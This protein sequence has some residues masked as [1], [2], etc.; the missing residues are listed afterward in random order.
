MNEIGHDKKLKQNVLAREVQERIVHYYYYQPEPIAKGQTMELLVDYGAV[1]EDTRER[2][3]YGKANIQGKIQSDSDEAA[4]FKRNLV[5]RLAIRELIQ[6]M[7]FMEIKTLVEFFE[8]RII[9]PLIEITDSYLKYHSS[10]NKENGDKSH[11]AQQ[12]IPTKRQLVARFRVKWIAGLFRKQIDILKSKETNLYRDEARKLYNILSPRRLKTPD[13]TTANPENN[14]SNTLSQLQLTE[15]YGETYLLLSDGYGLF[16]PY[17]PTLWCEIARTL[18]KDLIKEISYLRKVGKQPHQ[19]AEAIYNIATAAASSIQKF[20][21]LFTEVSN[22]Q[23]VTE[24]CRVLGFQQTD[25]KVVVS[26]LTKALPD[27]SKAYRVCLLQS[28]VTSGRVNERKTL[29]D[30][31]DNICISLAPGSDR[32]QQL[33]PLVIRCLSTVTAAQS[34]DFVTVLTDPHTSIDGEW[35]LL[36]QVIRV[37]HVI[38]IHFMQSNNNS[39]SLEELCAKVGVNVKNA[40]QVLAVKMEEPFP[41][42]YCNYVEEF[43]EEETNKDSTTLMKESSVQAPKTNKQTQSLK[44]NI[45]SQARWDL[46]MQRDKQMI[47]TYKANIKPT[48]QPRYDESDGSL[49]SG[50][51]IEGVPRKSSNHVDLYWYSKTN[52]KMRSRVEVGLFLELLTECNFDEEEAWKM[53]PASRKSKQYSRSK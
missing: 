3:G 31:L 38:S 49:P 8:N 33:D 15:E 36:W 18:C 51:R 39:Y 41:S 50:W 42:I 5:D 23:G 21:T 43:I 20:C 10:P 34:A 44:T 48:R 25:N 11:T 13:F 46:M 40:E 19:V 26:H 45:Y 2:K 16:H 47:A 35:Y 7:E 22:K 14:V 24:A 12:L 32:H 37:A 9:T 52:K 28:G 29:H 6:S 1:Y 27:L 17:D 53:F 30:M 4:N